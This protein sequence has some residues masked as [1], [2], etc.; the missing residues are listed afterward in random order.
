MQIH[1]ESEW[2]PL[3]PTWCVFDALVNPSLYYT[4][5]FSAAKVT[6]RHLLAPSTS[7]ALNFVI[8]VMFYRTRHR[9]HLRAL[10]QVPIFCVGL[11]ISCGSLRIRI[12]IQNTGHNVV[13]GENVANIFKNLLILLTIMHTFRLWLFLLFVCENYT[14]VKLFVKNSSIYF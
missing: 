13:K 14:F 5:I 7:S 10:V 3:S 11:K 2:L 4:T 12:Q 9:R 8:R 1:S 6:E